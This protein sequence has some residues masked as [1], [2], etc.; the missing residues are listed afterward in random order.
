MHHG[1]D[2][3]VRI[4]NLAPSTHLVRPVE[5]R[6]GRRACGTLHVMVPV[7][8]EHA[9]FLALAIE[10][11]VLE[12]D[13]AVDW[14][15]EVIVAEADS[16]ADMV[17]LAGL[18]R[19]QPGEV[20]ELLNRIPGSADPSTV[21]RRL[22]GLLLRQLQSDARSLDDVTILLRQMVDANAVPEE[23]AAR[24]EHFDI[25]LVCAQDGLTLE[26]VEDIRRQL[27]EFLAEAST[28]E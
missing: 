16:L 24:C 25:A 28:N 2:Q 19:P 27:V 14:A 26:T 10:H 17:E 8:R 4:F 23:L 6:Q 9:D 13:A 3:D 21:F 12:P 5:N 22:L 20:I 7:T 18:I 15:C 1:P 11:G